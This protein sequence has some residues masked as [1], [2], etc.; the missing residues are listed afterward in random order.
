MTLS[1][2]MA[3]CGGIIMTSNDYYYAMTILSNQCVVFNDNSNI[4]RPEMTTSAGHSVLIFGVLPA[5]KLN[6][7]AIR[8]VMKPVIG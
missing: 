3:Y 5:V 7:M 6:V 2:V 4:W 8:I 1:I